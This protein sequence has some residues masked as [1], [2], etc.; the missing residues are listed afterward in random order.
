MHFFSLQKF[1][2]FVSNKTHTFMSTNSRIGKL[3]PDGR[4]KAISCHYDGYIKGGVGENLIR[5]YEDEKKIDALLELGNLS[6]LGIEIGEKQNFD[7]YFNQNP[8]WCLAYGRDRG[9]SRTEAVYLSNELSFLTDNHWDYVYL[10]KEGAWHVSVLKE[11]LFS[12]T[13]LLTA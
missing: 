12:H 5:F 13:S 1:H 9:E 10:F 11:G 6:C 7:D 3:L 2:I 8:H 4:V